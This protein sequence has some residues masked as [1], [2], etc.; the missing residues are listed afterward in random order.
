MTL[1]VNACVRK[2]SRTMMLADLFLRSRG[3]R[4][5]KCGWKI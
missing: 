1:F 5:K 4:I 3:S 2:E